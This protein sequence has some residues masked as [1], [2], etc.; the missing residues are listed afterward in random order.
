MLSQHRAVADK[1]A[2][3]DLR[4]ACAPLLAVHSIFLNAFSKRLP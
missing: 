1:V 4:T 3:V 2:F